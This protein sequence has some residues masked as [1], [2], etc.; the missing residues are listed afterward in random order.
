MVKESQTYIERVRHV[1]KNIQYL[2][3]PVSSSFAQ[4]RPGQSA[5]ARMIDSDQEK[6]RWDPYLRE[7]WWPVAMSTDRRLIIERP[8]I[9][10]Y[11]PGDLVSLLAPIG[12]P[13]Q[14]RRTLRNVLLIVYNTLPT[15]FMMLL[16]MLLKNN[17]SITLVLLG[18]AVKY[19]LQ[20]ISEEV[21]II[22]AEEGLVWKDQVMT[23]GW[24]DQIF[25]A[26]GQDD[27]MCYFQEIMNLIEKRRT[28][29]PQN[30]IFGVFQ[31]IFPCGVG[32]CSS[33][34]IRMKQ[35]AKL[36]CTDGPTLDLTQVRW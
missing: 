34:M 26:V 12:R 3:L 33:C 11:Q 32:A 10:H 21:E 24:A 4:I 36:S 35:G 31:P 7:Q 29:I 2:E 15:P 5:L 16:S 17:V 25:V 13:F 28:T 22:H 30:Y 8:R 20:Y 19:D 14:F 27:E 9:A 1:N 18:D 23:L 6:E